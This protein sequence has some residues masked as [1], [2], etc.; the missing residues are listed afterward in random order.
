MS[1]N[2]SERPKRRPTDN[3]GLLVAIQLERV[4][5]ERLSQVAARHEA[6]VLVQVSALLGMAG[7]KD[8]GGPAREASERKKKREK[9]TAFSECAPW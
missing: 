1:E 9:M 3:L 4:L 6:V 2:P 8:A 5:F 7:E